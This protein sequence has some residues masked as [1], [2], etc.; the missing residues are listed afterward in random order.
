M[1]K[2]AKTKYIYIYTP[3]CKNVVIEKSKKQKDK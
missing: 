2:I 1:L 3:N